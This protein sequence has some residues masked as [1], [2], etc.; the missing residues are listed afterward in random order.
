MSISPDLLYAV[1]DPR[2]T[3]NSAIA[4][5]PGS[6][7]PYDASTALTV[8]LPS[9]DDVGEGTV[10]RVEKDAAVDFTPN[11]LTFQCAAGNTF[12]NGSSTKTF[13]IPGE[14]AT[15][16][17]AVFGSV[18]QWLVKDRYVPYVD[19]MRFYVDGQLSV[20]TGTNPD[21]VE[22][23]SELLLVR[24]TVVTPSSGASI[25]VDLANNGSTVFLNDGDRPNIV[26]G[27]KTDTGWPSARA[28]FAVGDQ[29]TPSILQV[30]SPGNEGATLIVD[31]LLRRVS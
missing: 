30:G 25:K 17:A 1:L 21:T 3:I 15:L 2:Q 19:K 26:A 9:I 12:A 14:H 28:S 16:Q 31:A 13:Y 5:D 24:A 18:K 11:T 7:Q 27:G 23:P 29:V 22:F 10:I 6:W 20:Q 8:P 4:P